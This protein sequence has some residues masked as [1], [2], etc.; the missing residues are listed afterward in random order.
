[1]NR[2]RVVVRGWGGMRM[3]LRRARLRACVLTGRAIAWLLAGGRLMLL[4]LVATVAAVLFLPIKW[5]EGV[6][7]LGGVLLLVAAVR[8][9]VRVV[10]EGFDDFRPPSGGPPK[11][12]GEPVKDRSTA[13]LLANRLA[14]MRDLYGF[15]DDP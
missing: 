3:Y 11:N 1:M 8:A 2:T 7:G 14:M 9:R 15:V 13:V 10:I 4:A 6:I 5:W 12:A